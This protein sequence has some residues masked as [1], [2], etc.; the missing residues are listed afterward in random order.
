MNPLIQLKKATAV[1]FV[2]L[3]CFALSPISLAVNPPPDGGYPNRNTAEG[4]NALLN[5][6]TGTGNTA[7]GFRS[8]LSDTTGGRNTATGAFSLLTNTTGN[9]NTANGI[10][11]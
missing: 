10:D 1:L 11:S 4:T 3:A 5:L 8:L 6:T 9:A 2:V 7:L